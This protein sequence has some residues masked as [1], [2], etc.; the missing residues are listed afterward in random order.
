MSEI[1]KPDSRFGPTV[2]LELRHAAI[3]ADPPFP[4]QP[5][6][7]ETIEAVLLAKV[8]SGRFG[9]SDT[10]LRYTH[11]M[12]CHKDQDVRDGYNTQTF[13]RTGNPDIVRMY[14]SNDS[15]KYTDLIVVYVERQGRGTS[16]EHLRV[17]LD[18]ALPRRWPTD[19]V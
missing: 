2:L 14:D 6:F 4:E 1:L 7:N 12:I 16:L 8:G 10:Y 18:R 13:G 3:G 5:A 15:Q 19:A 17:Y 9:N 11:W